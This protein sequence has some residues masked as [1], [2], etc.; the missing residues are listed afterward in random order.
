MPLITSSVTEQAVLVT[1]Q[2]TVKPGQHLKKIAL[3]NA[4]GTPYTGPAPL[5]AAFQANST[6]T[7]VA[8]VVANFNALLTKLKTAGLM[9][10]A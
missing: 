9:A 10:S 5:V 7:D 1:T 2:A 3:F 8:G 6:A 4:N